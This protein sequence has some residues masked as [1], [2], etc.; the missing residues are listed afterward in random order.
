MFAAEFYGIPFYIGL[1]KIMTM[2]HTF[3]PIILD[4]PFIALVLCFLIPHGFGPIYYLSMNRNLTILDWN[5]RGINSQ[6]RWN[7][8]RQKN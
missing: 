2:R 4:C 7:D 1:Y 8:I 6:T 5:L 3:S